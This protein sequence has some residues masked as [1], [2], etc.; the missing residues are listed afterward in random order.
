MKAA[1]ANPSDTTIAP[2][3]TYGDAGVNIEAGDE[4][5]ERIRPIVRRTFTP[6][7][8]DDFGGFAGAFRLDYDQRLF[9]RNYKDP[10]LIS[11]ADGVGSKVLVAI[12]SRRFETVGIDLVAMN[13]NDLVTT[14]AEPLFLLD[15]VAVHKLEPPHVAEIIAGIA[16]GCEIAGCALLGGETAEMPDLYAPSH[17]DLAAFAVGV[18]ERRKLARRKRVRPGDVIIGLASDGLHSNGYALARKV[19]L[20][21]ARLSLDERVHSLGETL[22]EALLRPTRIYVKPVLAALHAYAQKMPIHGM[23]HVTGGGIPGNLPRM[24]PDDCDI[25]LHAGTWPIPPIFGLIEHQGVAEDEMYRVFNMGIGF[26]L[27]VYPRSVSPVLR[28]LERHG[29]RAY[30]IGRV[31]RGHG[32]VEIN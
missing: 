17:F 15:Y 30:V 16:R 7:V 21:D 9:A 28:I 13:V 20:K 1:S 29:E 5:V 18:V 19:L 4:L 32:K 14:G 27:A 23:A 24:L 12:E 6:R 10:V 8:I 22:A 25:I 31:R 2:R 3:A 11:C 26:A